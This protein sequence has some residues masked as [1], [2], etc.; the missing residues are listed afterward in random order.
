MRL[1]G[2]QENSI[3]PCPL[4]PSDRVCPAQPPCPRPRRPWSLDVADPHGHTH[5]RPSPVH[6]VPITCLPRR[7]PAR[8]PARNSFSHCSQSPA[9]PGFRNISPRRARVRVEA[10]PAVPDIRVA[11]AVEEC[12]LTASHR[13]I[14]GYRRA[15]TCSAKSL[16]HV[17]REVHI[18][19]LFISP[20][21]ASEHVF[22]PYRRLLHDHALQRPLVRALNPY[23]FTLTHHHPAHLSRQA[24]PTCS[25][26]TSI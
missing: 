14:A 23:F 26:P 20:P 8:S 2:G 13:T 10:Q 21:S 7:L 16:P 3:T 12:S 5:R 18:I 15:P 1:E 17:V 22:A 24:L 11:P 25:S 4:P 19:P 9:L 6:G